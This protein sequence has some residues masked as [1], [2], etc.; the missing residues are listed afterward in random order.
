[1]L[2]QKDPDQSIFSRWSFL[3]GD[4]QSVIFQRNQEKIVHQ[5]L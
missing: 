3:V 4:F 1:M 5:I 2:I